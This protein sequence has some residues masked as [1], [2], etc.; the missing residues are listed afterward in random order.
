[1]KSQA[2]LLAACVHNL[3]ISKST[4]L[5]G[6]VSPANRYVSRTHT[7]GELTLKNLEE[8][9]KLSGWIEFKRMG[10]FIILRDS[11]GST[12]LLISKDVCVISCHTLNLFNV[13]LCMYYWEILNNFREMI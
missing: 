13:A 3:V 8:E 12:Q 4:P 1:M 6:R 10:Q 9:V 7:C 5:K 2:S 11:Y